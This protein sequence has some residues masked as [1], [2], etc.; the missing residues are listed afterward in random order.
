MYQ[1]SFDL[2]LAKARLHLSESP[3]ILPQNFLDIIAQEAI[4]FNLYPE[5]GSES[6][7]NALSQHW[8]VSPSKVVISN[9]CDEA[10]LNTFLK[11][12]I[13][14]NTIVSSNSYP[15]YFEIAHLAGQDMKEVPPGSISTG[16][17][18]NVRFYRF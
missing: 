1:E 9:G 12:G 3:F 7:I 17:L 14:G 15:G 13:S 5:P 8:G 10:I 16:C 4:N 2:S 6:A 11:F 18:E